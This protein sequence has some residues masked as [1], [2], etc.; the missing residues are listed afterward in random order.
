MATARV[1]VCSACLLVVATGVLASGQPPKPQRPIDRVTIGQAPAPGTTQKIVGG[2]PAQPGKYPFQ[3]ALISA[4]TP[5]GQEHFGQFCGG[6][7]ID[8]SWVVTAA[9]CVPG[10]T[11]DEVDVYIGSNVLP[12]GRG[13][14]GGQA[15]KRLSVRTE[16]F[17]H[18]NYDPN[19]NDNDIALLHLKTDAPAEFVPVPVATADL[20]KTKGAVGRTVTVI[21]WGA[22]Q[23]GGDTTPKLREVDVQVQD[24]AVCLTNYKD[25]IPSA[26]ITGNMFCAGRPQGGAD[27]CQGDSGGF[28]GAAAD[29]STP[30]KP[31][32]VQLGIVSWGIGCARP[33]LFGVYTRIANYNAWIQEVMKGS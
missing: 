20:D 18:Q 22:T 26:Q 9:H 12:A 15:G 32:F 7:L 14:A 31:T 17:S 13:N 3:V 33:K 27:S 10:T 25:A 6:S 19:T 4:K 8:K 28:I 24:S 16:I 5:V 30:A 23:E 2:K 29:G 21:G 1:R 11:G